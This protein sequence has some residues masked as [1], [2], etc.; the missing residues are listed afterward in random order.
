MPSPTCYPE[1]E[2]EMPKHIFEDL[3]R[4]CCQFRILMNR[5]LKGRSMSSVLWTDLK[6]NLQ[7]LGLYIVT[8]FVQELGV[9]VLG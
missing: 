7:K 6:L 8:S 4:P 5:V 9:D 3:V 2:R 1:G